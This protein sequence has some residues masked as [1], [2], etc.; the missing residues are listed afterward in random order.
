MKKLFLDIHKHPVSYIVATIVAFLIGFTFFALFYF[1][2]GKFT[3]IG[4]INGTSVGGAVLVGSCILT[5]VTREGA[6][7]FLTYGFK[8]MFTSMFGRQANKYNDF[9]EYKEQKNIKREAAGYYYLS[10]LVVGL[11]HFIAFGVLEIVY[12]SLY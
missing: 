1:W 12:H 9:V 6:F 4:A 7:D 5:W 11:L 3:I 2:F 8:Q 10:L